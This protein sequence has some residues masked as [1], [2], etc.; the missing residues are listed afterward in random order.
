MIGLIP[1][2]ISQI[3]TGGRLGGLGS[4]LLLILGIGAGSTL[5]ML[6]VALAPRQAYAWP[7]IVLLMIPISIIGGSESIWLRLPGWAKT[8]AAI[9]PARWTFEGL[10][11]NASDRLPVKVAESAPPTDLA[12]PYFPAE[13]ERT[14][15]RGA[16]LALA[17][18]LLGWGAAAA[19]IATSP[20]LPPGG[21]SAP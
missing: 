8:V 10:L 20:R 13:T 16:A 9:N 18:M 11:V 5:G 4:L 6:V 19:F 2:F 12:E 1:W 21:R 15:P 17:A 3:D 14:G 7:V